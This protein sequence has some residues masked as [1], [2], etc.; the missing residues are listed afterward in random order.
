M[1]INID[2]AAIKIGLDP[3]TLTHEKMAQIIADAV[4]FQNPELEELM[5]A[6]EVLES[7][8]G[9]SPFKKHCSLCILFVSAVDTIKKED[10]PQKDETILKDESLAT[11]EIVCKKKGGWFMRIFNYY[12][13]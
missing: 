6:G 10:E 2:A 4:N 13:S 7:L 8:S 1:A 3:K 9:K 11:E 5:T 12:F